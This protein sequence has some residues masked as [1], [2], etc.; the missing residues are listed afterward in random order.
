MTSDPTNVYVI[1]G[2]TNNIATQCTYGGGGYYTRIVYRGQ[3]YYRNLPMTGY[4]THTLT[5]NNKWH[6]CGIGGS[7]F[8]QAHMAPRSNHSGGV[9][10]CFADGSVHFVKD[11]INLVPWRA[12][13]TRSGNEVISANS[14]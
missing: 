2:G 9:N 8:V 6:D 5:P 7:S 1:N 3:E 12:L 4:Y 13:G 11:S 10:V 14:Y